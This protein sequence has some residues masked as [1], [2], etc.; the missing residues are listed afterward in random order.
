M[1][2][3]TTPKINEAL[4]KLGRKQKEF[5]SHQ[6]LTKLVHDLKQSDLGNDCQ[7]NLL[8]FITGTQFYH[9][10]KKIIPPSKEYQKMMDDCRALLAEKEYLQMTE[11]LETKKL[12]LSPGS[13]WKEVHK[14]TTSIINVLF[15]VVAVFVAVFY[16][17]ESMQMDIGLRVLISLAGALIVA[18]AEGWF[19]TKDWVISDI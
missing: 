14:M 2:L 7:Y 19:F 4:E 8:D 18:I 12:S 11:N 17:G 3:V 1:L 16:L 5:I 6:E 13:E 15:S 10:T 9:P